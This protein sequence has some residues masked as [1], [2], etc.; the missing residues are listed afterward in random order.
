MVGKYNQETKTFDPGL[1]MA[2]GLN[3]TE[4][5]KEYW[6]IQAGIPKRRAW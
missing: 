2:E 6:L 4:A 3:R 5:D 1:L